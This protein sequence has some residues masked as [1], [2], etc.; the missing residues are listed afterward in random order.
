MT[1]WGKNERLQIFLAEWLHWSLE[2][3]IT[4][5]VHLCC[6][7]V[8]IK[9]SRDKSLC[10]HLL[11]RPLFKASWKL[12]GLQEGSRQW[13]FSLP[14]LPALI[15]LC[16][17]A[18]IYHT[19]I[20]GPALFNPVATRPLFSSALLTNCCRVLLGF[21]KLNTTTY[22]TLGRALSGP[23]LQAFSDG[24]GTTGEGLL[25]SSR[26]PMCCKCTKGTSKAIHKKL[27]NII[28]V[29]A[30]LLRVCLHPVS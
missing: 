12:T 27:Q 1:D 8:K 5:Q 20:S 3:K 15:Y 29:L 16:D 21:I 25:Q 19:C 6:W 11:P 14:P 13:Y 9:F 24:N 23:G 7:S 10:C 26:D 4:F 2:R 22:T 28:C 17:S 30:K 18:P